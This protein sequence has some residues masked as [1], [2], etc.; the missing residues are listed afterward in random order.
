MDMREYV[1]TIHPAFD[2]CARVWVC[3][4]QEKAV[5]IMPP[6]WCNICL[7]FPPPSLY[8]YLDDAWKHFNQDVS[9]G[10]VNITFL[11]SCVCECMCVCGS[12][13]QCC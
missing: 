3:V 6:A 1:T 5:D 9:S 12:D 13:S 8:C 7:F 4:K 10:W 2:Y 11:Y